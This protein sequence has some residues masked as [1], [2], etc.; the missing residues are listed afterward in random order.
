MS[1][2]PRNEEFSVAALC[3]GAALLAGAALFLN[4]ADLRA[5][6]NSPPSTATSVLSL[7]DSGAKAGATVLGDAQGVPPGYT[8]Q[9]YPDLTSCWIVLDGKFGSRGPNC[10]GAGA[11]NWAPAYSFFSGIFSL[12][13]SGSTNGKSV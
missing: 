7:L 12:N 6:V 8:G 4:G 1:F 11:S 13:P 3:A 2:F 5:I 10:P 9:Q